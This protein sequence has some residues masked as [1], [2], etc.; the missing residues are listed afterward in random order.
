[1]NLFKIFTKFGQSAVLTLL[2][3]FLFI[4]Y[5]SYVIA[6]IWL[7]VL[8]NWQPLV[9]GIIF[10]LLSS[11][12]YSIFLLPALGLGGVIGFFSG[13]K[14]DLAVQFFSLI[15]ILYQNAIMIFWVYYTFKIFLSW[16][17]PK[18]FIPLLIL[19]YN[20]AMGVFCF[21]AKGESPDSLGTTFGLLL[22]FLTCLTMI[23]MLSF[24]GFSLTPLII[25]YIV[26]SVI[27]FGMIIWMQQETETQN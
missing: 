14:N 20:V 27:Q 12:V 3:I 10:S 13:R 25:L 2:S 17:T 8:G 24:T 18:N 4:F 15:A 26:A 7:L 11:W 21:M 19:S 6:A 23:F 22:A 5:F 1:M 16:E 9:Q